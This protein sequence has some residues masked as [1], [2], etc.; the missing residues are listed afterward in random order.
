[1][2]D[3]DL[4]PEAVERTCQDLL[5]TCK[6]QPAQ[7]PWPHRPQHKAIVTLRAL[8]DAL[9]AEQ[10]ENAVLRYVLGGVRGAIKTGR[11]EPLQIWLDQIN[12][13]L[14]A[15]RRTPT[16]ERVKALVGAIQDALGR[17]QV[18][19]IHEVLAAALRDMEED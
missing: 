2:T 12:I 18:T 16:D 1:M 13:A 7:I 3:P 5:D 17:Y 14:D 9:E 8:S 6:G 11:N 15:D 4:T 19:H 10:S